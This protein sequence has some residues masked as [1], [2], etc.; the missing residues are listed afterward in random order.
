MRVAALILLVGV[1]TSGCGCKRRPQ[2][3]ADG[4][5]RPSASKDKERLQGV[6]AVVSTEF[7]DKDEADVFN[8]L[9]FSF[10]G[11][12]LTIAKGDDRGREHHSYT[13][14][15]DTDP[16][17]LMLSRLSN[18]RPDPSDNEKREE[19]LYKFEGDFLVLAI[20]SGGG[21]R[22]TGFSAK[23]SSGRPR[24]T[25]RSKGPVEK[26]VPGS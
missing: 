16:K 10:V 1:I 9:R 20:P 13:L 14:N 6:W 23:D 24:S 19:W 11:D 7:G 2:G 12:K 18:A 15:T 5:E 26:P 21:P 8:S 4:G 3:V 17:V 25:G 22:P